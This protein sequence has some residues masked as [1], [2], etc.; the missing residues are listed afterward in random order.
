MALVLYVIPKY[1]LEKKEKK[2]PSSTL[3]AEPLPDPEDF[4]TLVVSQAEVKS[5][6]RSFPTGSGGGGWGGSDG[7]RPQRLN[8][9]I[10]CKESG[11]DFV[12][13]LTDFVNL[14]LE[15]ECSERILFGGR[16]SALRKIDGGIRP[17]AVSCYW[18]RL[19]SR[20]ANNRAMQTV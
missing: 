9:L 15:G 14:L 1:C 11:L 16:L 13:R 12:S 7:L 8:D 17:I 10:N 5:A 6:I 3:G 20:I 4:P 18:R 19:A 2:N